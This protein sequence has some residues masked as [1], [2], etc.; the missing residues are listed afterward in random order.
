MSRMNF[1]SGV[2]LARFTAS[3][4]FFSSNCALF[5]SASTDWRNSDSRRSSCWCIAFAASSISLNIRLVGGG[6]CA[7]T[8]S[9]AASTF[10]TAEQHGQVISKMSDDFFPITAPELDDTP[11]KPLRALPSCPSCDA[12]RPSLQIYDVVPLAR[13]RVIQFQQELRTI[14]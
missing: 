5:F 7:I 12:F 1:S 2:S 9:T 4:N 14:P 3:A 10:S 13:H 11:A 8:A 6:V